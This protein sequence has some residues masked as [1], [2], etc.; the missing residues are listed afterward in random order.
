MDNGFIR[1]IVTTLYI[2]LIVFFVIIGFAY[3]NQ[4]NSRFH[5]NYREYSDDWYVDGV[6]MELPYSNKNEFMMSNVLPQVYGDQFLIIKCYYDTASVFVDGVEVYRSR[7]N[8]L[9]G[10]E[11]NVGKK[12]IHVPLDYNYSGKLVTAKITLQKAF[13]GAEVYDC[14]ISTRSGYGLSILKK[15]IVA[16]VLFVVL[17]FSGLTEVLIAVHFILKKSLILRKLSF[18]ALLFSGFFSI[19][20]GIW[21]LCETR[22]PYVVFGNG[23][24]FAILEIISFMLLPLVFFELVRAVNFRVSKIDNIVDGIFAVA[25]VLC[26]VLCLTGVFDWGDIVVIAHVIDIIMVF[27]VAYYCM[28]SIKAE[29]R[30][31]ERK[32]IAIGNSIFLLVCV[33]ALAMY[34]NNIDSNYNIIVIVGLLVYISTQIGLIYR[35][36]G[37]KVEEEA[38]LVQVKELAYTDELTRLNNRRYFYEELAALEDRNLSA[39]TS[40]VYCDVNRLKFYNDTMGHDACD[41][42]I[43]GTAECLK[44]AFADNKTSVICRMGGDE[45]V[46][47]LI[48]TEAELNKR[49]D[50]FNRITKEWN[51]TFIKEISA[52]I[53]TASMRDNP[54]ASPN[55]LCKIADDNM[56]EAKKNY[57]SQSGN[58]R[59][60]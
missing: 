11:S 10:S 1:K 40:I 22:L 7:D 52:S 34:I 28:T 42:L 19:L 23:T 53:G 35:R 60:K 48:A 56:Y 57:Y 47:M 24:G 46:V 59:R 39:D 21:L 6:K 58:D 3:S 44:K 51:G 50:L 14:L 37:L 20:A 12:E 8:W 18:E 27:V 5:E 32:L 13:Y 36:L 31:S 26:F 41:E 43:K 2:I 45:F 38:E 54:D 4:E 30:R 16:I 15:E 55:D 33:V 9:F 17:L 29:K 25:I 49:I